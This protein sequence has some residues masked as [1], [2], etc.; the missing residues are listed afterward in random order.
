M[1]I[2]MPKTCGAG[3]NRL[4]T[5]TASVA[6]LLLAVSVRAEIVGIGDPTTNSAR[7]FNLTARAGYVSVAD[8]GSIYS[9][10][11]SES[12]NS[13]MQLPGPTLR[14]MQ[15]TPVTITLTNSLPVAAGNTSMVFPGLT[16]TASG[17]ETGA[18]TNEAAPGGTV[19]YTFT[20][21]KPGTYQYRVYMP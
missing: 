12:S 14:V 1:K 21:S 16:V 4:L 20:A 6:L 10:G 2:S 15:G 5:I 11:Y 3:L 17:G 19:T 9:W 13:Y 7:T 8:G 18:L